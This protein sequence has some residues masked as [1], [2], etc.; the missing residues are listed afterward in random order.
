MTSAIPLLTSQYITVYTR[1]RRLGTS[2]QTLDL[3]TKGLQL[4]KFEKCFYS[5]LGEDSLQ[6]AG[7]D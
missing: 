7:K 3:L 5:L 1:Y 4:G 2:K 6:A